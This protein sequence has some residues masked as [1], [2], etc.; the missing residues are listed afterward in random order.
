MDTPAPTM[1][2]PDFSTAN[3]GLDHSLCLTCQKNPANP[4]HIPGISVG[5][6]ACRS[7]QRKTVEKLRSY[8]NAALRAERVRQDQEQ[9]E[10]TA[11]VIKA[12]RARRAQ[13]SI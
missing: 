8:E 10:R 11:A 4:P 12:R 1:P 3:R 7:C 9:A 13:R 2:A 5:G 6:I